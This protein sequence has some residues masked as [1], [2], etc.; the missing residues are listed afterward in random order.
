[1]V[2]RLTYPEVP[3]AQSVGRLKLVPAM[4]VL[5]GARKLLITALLYS[6]PAFGQKPE[7]DFV[8][9]RCRA[10]SNRPSWKPALTNQ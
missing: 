7:Y 2:S 10:A 1:M 4:I 8:A 9:I 3:E 6:T 5:T